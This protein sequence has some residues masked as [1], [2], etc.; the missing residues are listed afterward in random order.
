MEFCDKGAYL[1]DKVQE[2]TSTLYFEETHSHLKQRQ[3]D[4]VLQGH[5]GRTDAH[6]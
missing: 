3:I 6:S 5:L 4:F 1:A 2:V